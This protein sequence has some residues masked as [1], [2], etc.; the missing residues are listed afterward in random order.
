LTASGAAFNT[1]MGKFSN[2]FGRASTFIMSALG[3]RLGLWLPHPR[4]W[5]DGIQS[6]GSGALWRD[7]FGL[8]SLDADAVFV[9]D[10]GHFENTAVYELIRRHCRWIIVCDAGGDPDVNF[11]DLGNAI[12]RARLDFSA[13]I[14]VDLDV[15]K[16][17]PDGLAKQAVAVGDIFYPDGD[18]GIIVVV[19]PTLTGNEPPDVSNYAARNP[20]FPHQSTADQFFDEEQW[21]S[22]RRLGMHCM[23]GALWPIVSQETS[24]FADAFDELDS[25]AAAHA[26]TGNGIAFTRRRFADLRR[27]WYSTGPA[28]ADFSERASEAMRALNLALSD[29][30][31]S[32]LAAQI[33][34]EAA[35]KVAVGLDPRAY[36]NVP[37]EQQLSSVSL[38]R[39]AFA[40]F[41]QIYYEGNLGTAWSAPQYLGLMNAMARWMRAPFA[42]AW[43][44][45]LQSQNSQGFRDFVAARFGSRAAS[46]SVRL[47]E[48][49][50]NEPLP[51]GIVS[52]N[53]AP[54][55]VIPADRTRLVLVLSAIETDLVGPRVE[56]ARLDYAHDGALPFIAWRAHEL[57]VP[58]SLWG[59][60]LGTA[61]LQKV[62]QDEKFAAHWQY[63]VVP[64]NPAGPFEERKRHADMLQLYAGAGFVAV[65][66]YRDQLAARAINLLKC[67]KEDC[68]IMRRAPASAESES[69][70][71]LT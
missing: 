31:V 58:A 55:E 32:G 8:S 14:R 34:R 50:P 69:A 70:S 30:R 63:V 61:M 36:G 13:E 24:A 64:F 26:P 1:H 7:A 35:V 47:R 10:G 44:P 53:D 66:P 22:Y 5:R 29:A 56:A 68:V 37:R 20:Q 18:T 41:E 15:L 27:H 12:R 28:R 57:E 2:D 48:V 65:D 39:D 17:G 16:P 46:G 60:G 23:R 52:I 71:S 25:I 6:A 67:W 54:V 21:E 11:N 40:R 62:R 51:A 45:I 33:R 42:R 49:T 9:S 3:L 59:T 38:L 43:W 4:K 19:K